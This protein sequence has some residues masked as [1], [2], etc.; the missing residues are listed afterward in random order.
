MNVTSSRAA[1]AAATS[2]APADRA[3]RAGKILLAGHQ[4]LPFLE[5]GQSIGAA[6]LRAILTDTFGGS[7]AEGFW[8]W[9][10]AYEATEVAQVLFLRKFGAAIS[11]RTNVPKAALAMLTKV[12]SLIPTHT[13]RSEE[14]QQLQQFST[15]LPLGLIAAHAAGLK[16][17]DTVLEPSAGT[18]LMAIFGELA[19]ARLSLNEYAPVRHGLLEQLFLGSVVSQHDAAHIDDYLDRSVRP[20]VVLMNPPFSAGVHVEGRMA[21][22]AWRHLASAF[23]RL[24]PGGRL[25]A[26][27]GSSLSPDNPKWHDAFVRLQ[28]RGTVLFSAAID[29]S[30]YA[31]HGTTMETR[32]TVI[33]KIAAADPKSLIASHGVAPDLETLLSWI[34][35]LPPRS[36]STAPN[37]IGALSNGIV[38]ACAA[39]MAARKAADTFRPA[40]VIAPASRTTPA[41]RAQQP[42]S[43][44]PLRIDDE[45]V[46]LD[47]EL[48]DAAPNTRVDVADGIYEPYRLQAIHIPDAKPHPDKLVESVAMASV[49]P[50]K[51]SYRPHLPKRIITDGDLSDAQLESVIYAG[52]AHSGYLAGHWSVDA[53]FDNLKAVTPETEGAVRFRRGWFLGD[54]TGAGK[55]RQAAGIILDNWLQGRRRHL[56]ISK[57]ETLIE[58]AQRDWSALGQ[59]KLLVT[60]LSRF[61]QGEAI[62]LEEGILFVTFATLR[63]DEREGKQSRVQQIVDWLGNDFDGVIIFD[64]GHAMANAAGGKSERGEKAASQQGRAG[65]RLQRALPDARVVY[66]SATGASEVESLAYAERL[67]LWG[68]A[69]F[70]FSTRSE[71]IAAIEDGGVAT[72]EVLARDLKAM[73]LYASRSLSFE[74]VEYD[75][76]EHELTKEQVRIYD[77]YAEA[78]QIIHNNL[79]EALEASGIISSKGTLN[80]NAKAAARSAFESSKQRFFNHLLTSM[81]TPALINAIDKDVEEGHAAIVQ[82]IST[83]QSLTERRL[84]EIPTEEWGDVQV[85][86]TPRE[87]VAE[88]LNHSFPTQLFEEYS[89]AEGN[90]LSRP[91]YDAAGQPGPVPRSSRAP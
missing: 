33:D 77:S 80:K 13:R 84:A 38:R 55:G 29:G 10:D 22:A 1:N 89:D 76:L 42:T 75:I 68:S 63:T 8:A 36:P 32:L 51:P 44:P 40:A 26:I 86:V 85:D 4:L 46:E 70:P 24:A 28:E 5:R 65:L 56:W 7:D 87:I 91:V 23:A 45:V 88:Y 6:D 54:G 69:D 59:E 3:G 39:K 11:A 78:F 82:I 62:K 60:P 16:A 15:P 17:D 30:V 48:R 31:R 19:H 34:S 61:R 52:E 81:K 74:G 66:V 37:S 20:T 79:N 58:D 90:L 43:P 18:G 21:D 50:P 25:V 14:S 64:E 47:Y 12:A 35:G 2:L 9:K 49:A 41:V 73:G 71:F 83:G 53:S 67:G 57:S 72:M 27:T